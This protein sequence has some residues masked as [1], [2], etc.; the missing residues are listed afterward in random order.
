MELSSNSQYS[1]FLLVNIATDRDRNSDSDCEDEPAE[2]WRLCNKSD[3]ETCKTPLDIEMEKVSSTKKKGASRRSGSSGNVKSLY[4]HN[5]KRKRKA[6]DEEKCNN[7]DD[8]DVSEKCRAL[9]IKSSTG[10][11]KKI[12]SKMSDDAGSIQL[13]STQNP[14]VTDSEKKFDPYI[15]QPL[16]QVDG[17]LD[18]CS[19]VKSNE[20]PDVGN[21]RIDGTQNL[22]VID[23][24][25]KIDTYM[26]QSLGHVDES[27]D[28]YPIV[29]SKRKPKTSSFFR[30]VVKPLG[31][32]Q[33]VN[34]TWVPPVSVYALIQEELYKDPWKVLV[35][36]ML[37]NK[38]SGT[39]V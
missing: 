7:I 13:D 19:I 27:L 11:R 12:R 31:Q 38:T 8:K 20:K 15:Q 39:Q 21:I 1:R 37:L 34:K 17:S 14:A 28:S 18:S 16:G 36:C 32:R 23:S 29:K 33:I 22:R 3:V 35:A 26:Q 25:N 6:G 30:P 5:G 9:I 4:F 2:F 24:E 10:K